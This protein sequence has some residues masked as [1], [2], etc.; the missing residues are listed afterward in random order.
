MVLQLCVIDT[1]C[2]KVMVDLFSLARN[3]THHS[4]G[5]VTMSRAF[6]EHDFNAEDLVFGAFCWIS[7]I[8]GALLNLLAV[9]VLL[10]GHKNSK[11][12]RVQLV[13]LAIVDTL[14]SM[15]EPQIY[16][17]HRFEDSVDLPTCKFAGFAQYCTLTLSTFCNTVISIDRFIAVYFPLK[18]QQYKTFHKVV[19]AIFIWLIAV[20]VDLGTIFNCHIWEIYDFEWC[21][22]SPTRYAKPLGIKNQHAIRFAKNAIP[23]FIIVLM[24]ILIG[25]RIVQWKTKVGDAFASAEVHQRELLVKKQVNI[26]YLFYPHWPHSK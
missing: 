18:A 8:G 19:T 21:F 10:T 7:G 16:Y 12:M 9:L 4:L 20:A 2:Y 15:V 5:N 11:E 25:L 22:C 3:Q 14:M 6:V 24:Y 13:N 26:I 1:D 17:H 23:A